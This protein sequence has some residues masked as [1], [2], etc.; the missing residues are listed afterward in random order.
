MKRLQE[1]TMCK[2]AV[3][4]RGSMKDRKKE[5]ELRASLDPKYAHL[6]DDL[7]VEISALAPPAEA[8]ARIA[9]ALAE[10]RK[11]LIPDNNDVI[12]QE[13]MR[14]M[15]SDPSGNP[16]ERPIESES[17]SPYKRVA[18]PPTRTAYTYRQPVPV[19]AHSPVDSGS[20]SSR[21]VMPAKQK[22][23]SILDRAR[24]AMEESYRWVLLIMG[25][26]GFVL[27]K[28]C[29]NSARYEDPTVHYEPPPYEYSYSHGQHHTAPVSSRQRYEVPEYEP[30]EY[31][32]DY[33]RESP[34][35]SGKFYSFVPLTVCSIKFFQF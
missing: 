17:G 18:V 8:H 9:F 5:E 21:T 35:Y 19:P 13:Q 32:R 14:E 6:N 27:I 30:A 15:L 7:H 25:C 23:L 28:F 4:G 2:M 11:Y 16:I 33:Y 20:S 1:E 12:R 29:L 31:R 22:I 34:T 26:F 10:V 3:L 24:S